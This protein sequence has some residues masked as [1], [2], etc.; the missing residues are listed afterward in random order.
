MGY[1]RQEYWNGLPFT[2]P[3]AFTR[4]WTWVSYIA[5]RFFYY[6]SHQGKPFAARTP[7]LSCLPQRSCMGP[8]QPWTHSASSASSTNS[9]GL[10]TPFQL[11]LVTPPHSL[12]SLCKLPFPWRAIPGPCLL[13][14]SQHTAP[15]SLCRP[16]TPLR[17]WSFSSVAFPTSL[18]H[19]EAC[20]DLSF[21][22]R[23]WT[24]ASCS[25]SMES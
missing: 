18:S 9:S 3:G 6:L 1:S 20:G 16:P 2:S 21:L 11:A 23:D 15:P 8:W 5:D 17:H 14:T 25:G 7:I 13:G 19:C 4:D 10:M 12:H 24:H 22:T